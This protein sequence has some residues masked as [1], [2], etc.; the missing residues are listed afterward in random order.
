VDLAVFDI[1]GRRVVQ[2]HRG[3]LPAGERRF[4][5]RGLDGAGRRCAS[6]LYV[7]QLRTG[8]ASRRVKTVLLK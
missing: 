5:W 4:V 3:P 7:L 1:Q 6:G 8:G 2:L